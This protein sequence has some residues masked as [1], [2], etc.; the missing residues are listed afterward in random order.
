LPSPKVDH[1]FSQV[2]VAMANA[3]RANKMMSDAMAAFH[4]AASRYDWPTAEKEREN[5]KAASDAYLDHIAEAHRCMQIIE[6]K[7]I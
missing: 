4:T 7:T 6:P 2:S 1:F 3:S 5:F